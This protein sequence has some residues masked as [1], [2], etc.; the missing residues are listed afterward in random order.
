MSEKALVSIVIIFLNT[1]KFLGEAI[2]SIFAQTY[3]QWELLLVD[4]GSIDNSTAIAQHYSKQKPS[5]VHYLDH[6]GHRNCGKGASR[7]LG[8]QH[9]K[10]EYLA[11]LDADDLWLPHK[12]KEQVSILEKHKQVGMLYG[13][14]L[15]WFSWTKKPADIR[16]DFIPRL[17]IQVETPINRPELL[18]L[19]LRG[20][21]SIPCP[22]D[23]LV[24]RSVIEEVGGFDETFIGVNNIY[25]DQA[26]FAKLCLVTQIMAIDSCWDRYRQ[27]PQASM[28][29]AWQAGTEVEARS[30]FLRWL[31]GYLREQAVQDGKVWLAL[32]RELWLVQNPGWLPSG[33]HNVIRW[34]KK[35]LL[36]IEEYILPSSLS[37]QLWMQNQD[38]MVL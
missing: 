29:I 16:R 19:Y 2:E 12:L 18:P 3:D 32:R 35:W 22:S 13:K 34:A 33:T 10:G 27:H 15:Y 26:F 14:T 4:D 25:E 38:R 17:G 1:E 8:I 20:R 31:E 23:I 28:A 37:Y 5:K 6:P 36:R 30:F 9:A 11:F 24:R 7:N 21:A